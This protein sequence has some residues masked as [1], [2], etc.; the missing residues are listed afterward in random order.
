[1]TPYEQ[2]AGIVSHIRNARFGEMVK[3]TESLIRSGSWRDFI[4]PAG[5]HFRFRK[6]EFDYFLAAEELDATTLRYAYLKA[7]ATAAQLLRL[8]DI[9]GKGQCAN[10]DRRP[11]EEV[12]ALYAS[13]PGG[14][15]KRI[16][17]WGKAGESVVTDNTARIAANK[18]R[19]SRRQRL[20]KPNP[21][22][23]KQWQVT[24]CDMKTTAQ[25][26][27]EKLMK[28]PVLVDEVH[29]KLDTARRR[30]SG[31]LKIVRTKVS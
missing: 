3:Y 19:R 30:P 14:A 9:T 31:A 6:C 20:S 7:P 5:T 11:R 10:G 21:R 26:I 13:A 17:K 1:M 22:G 24:W 18:N 4:T 27:V 15:G 16:L 23:N 2:V 28:D 29:R 12:A 8:A 25:A